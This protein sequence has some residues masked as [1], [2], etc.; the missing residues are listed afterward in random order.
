MGCSQ[1][2]NGKQQI[3]LNTRQETLGLITSSGLKTVAYDNDDEIYMYVYISYVLFCFHS[4]TKRTTMNDAYAKVAKESH[5]SGDVMSIRK[6]RNLY[7]CKNNQPIYRS[8]S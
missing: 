3:E 5:V 2:K 4:H 6:I 8:L 1:S 7:N